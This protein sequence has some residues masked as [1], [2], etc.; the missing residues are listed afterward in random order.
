MEFPNDDISATV[1]Y[2]YMLGTDLLVA[3]VI[4]PGVSTLKVYLPPGIWKFIWDKQE[5][6]GHRFHNVIAI[7]GKPPA[8]YKK[9]SVWGPMFAQI[10]MKFPS[11]SKPT[12]HTPLITTSGNNSNNA[13]MRSS[14]FK[15]WNIIS[16][17]LCYLCVNVLLTMD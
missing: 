4:Q 10:Q 13:G 5:Y 6:D 9:N 17:L 15:D 11:I 7:L 2:Q 14:I 16:V 8:F 12:T 1:T 3:P